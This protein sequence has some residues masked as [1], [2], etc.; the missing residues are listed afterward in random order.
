[1]GVDAASSRG[2][3]AAHVPTVGQTCPATCYTCGANPTT[4]ARDDTV[5]NCPA[6][7]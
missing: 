4:T 1:M 5:V 3:V 6:C 2:T 7:V